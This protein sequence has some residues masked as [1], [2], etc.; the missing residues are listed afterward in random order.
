M[1][2]VLL[3]IS[4]YAAAAVV[5]VPLAQR[6]GFGSVLGYLAAGVVIGPVLGLVGSETEDVSTM[7]SSAWS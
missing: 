3:Q 4:I 6:L 1:E 5:A 2:T 7:P